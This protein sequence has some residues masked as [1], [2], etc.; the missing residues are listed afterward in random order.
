MMLRHLH[1]RVSRAM[2]VVTQRELVVQKCAMMEVARLVEKTLAGF[3]V[4]KGVIVAAG[5][6]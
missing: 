1:Q 6:G 5:T 3:D 2:M 4:A